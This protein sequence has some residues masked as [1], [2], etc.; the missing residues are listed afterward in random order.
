MRDFI[1]TCSG[2]NGNG[3]SEGKRSDSVFNPGPGENVHKGMGTVSFHKGKP[4]SFWKETVE[5]YIMERV[6]RVMEK[7]A[8]WH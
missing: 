3:A 7:P 2:F 6:K 8:Q 4:A 5:R 1:K